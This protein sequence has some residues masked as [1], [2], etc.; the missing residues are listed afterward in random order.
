MID[1][2]VRRILRVMF[3]NGLFENQKPGG[4][5]VDTPAQRAVARKA[6]AEG[7]VLLKNAGD[8][9]PLLPD[10]IHSIAVVGP[11]AAVAVTGGGGSSSVKTSHAISPL[12]AFANARAPVFRCSYA[13]SLPEAADL[14]AKADVALVFAGDS[15]ES[16]ERRPGSRIDG[17]ARRSGRIDRG[18]S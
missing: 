10:K 7:I 14:A 8:L 13:Q 9:L 1:D 15:A 12:D 11:N 18:R 6:A 5:E 3:A 16:G 2:K 4:G 17:S